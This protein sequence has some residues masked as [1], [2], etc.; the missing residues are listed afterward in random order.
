MPST[1]IKL[2]MLAQ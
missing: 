1:R 2:D